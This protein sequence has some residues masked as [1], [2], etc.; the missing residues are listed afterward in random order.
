LSSIPEKKFSKTIYSSIPS[1]KEFGG[2]YSV[3]SHKNSRKKTQTGPYLHF[4]PVEA[5]VGKHRHQN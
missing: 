1:F 2:T 5:L 3:R 4:A